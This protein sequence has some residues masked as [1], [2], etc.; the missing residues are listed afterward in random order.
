M[1]FCHGSS[2]KH[3]HPVSDHLA[4]AVRQLLPERDLCYPRPHTLLLELWLV[5]MRVVQSVSVHGPVLARSKRMTAYG[6]V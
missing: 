4:Y 1:W 5:V 6:D 2:L 3:A